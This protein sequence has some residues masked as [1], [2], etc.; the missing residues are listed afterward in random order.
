MPT[1]E[2][3]IKLRRDFL[4]YAG[5]R[6]R[7]IEAQAFEGRLLDDQE[8]SDAAAVCEQELIDDYSAG[9]VND[10]D[11]AV[12]QGWVEVSPRR[13]QR[14]QFARAFMAARSRCPQK[15]SGIGFVV[16]IAAMIAGLT[17]VMWMA[18]RS[19]RERAGPAPNAVKRSDAAAESAAVAKRNDLIAPADQ[20][21][22]VIAERM[23]GA[24]RSQVIS[25]NNS[26]ETLRV[27]LPEGASNDPYRLQMADMRDRHNVVIDESGLRPSVTGGRMYLVVSVRKGSLTPGSYEVTVSSK[28]D[29]F[30]ATIVVQ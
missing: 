12:L 29:S 14:V 7:G 18:G 26:A 3:M 22:L 30:I 20:V 10:A 24:Q 2:E 27:L 17:V 19:L 8:F 6:M 9:E 5:A 16:P 4:R 13:L 28:E 25:H 15:G 21:I 23:R 1:T 11:K